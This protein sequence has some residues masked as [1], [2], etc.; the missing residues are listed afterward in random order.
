L[1]SAVSSNPAAEVL[2]PV[3]W[4]HGGRFG[5]GGASRLVVCSQTSH[6]RRL[7]WRAV[8]LALCALVATVVP[9]WSLAVQ[10]LAFGSLSGRVVDSNGVGVAGV[11]VGI[12]ATETP[13]ATTSANGSYSLPNVLV[14]TSPYEILLSVPCRRDQRKTVT[15]DGAETV[16][17]TVPATPDTDAT[18]IICRPSSTPYEQ[19]SG[20]LGIT[21][22]SQEITF[23]LPFPVRLYGVD[24]TIASVGVNG[25]VSFTQRA[26][27]NNNFPLPE[28]TPGA[29]VFPFW[30]DLDV[31][32]GIGS[33]NIAVEGNAGTPE[34]RLVIEWRNV[35]FHDDVGDPNAPFLNFEVVFYENRRILFN[36]GTINT[37]ARYTRQ[38]G[39]SATVGIQNADGTRGFQRSF[40]QAVLDSG[41]G[42]EFVMPK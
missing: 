34:H 26:T 7:V 22:D 32:A 23:S 11:R 25:F 39:T 5:A 21:G 19:A 31:Q 42:I 38:R 33:V 3:P 8:V 15:V 2:N 4:E 24:Y 16:N 27:L 20:S 29:A 14:N 10:A 37:Q 28:F 40:N 6:C 13:F 35:R 12:L 18:G 30:D 9:G 1:W 17:F 41:Y 36:Y